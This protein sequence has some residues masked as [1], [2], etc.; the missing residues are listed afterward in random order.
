MCCNG[1]LA[2]LVAITAPS[3][4]VNSMGAVLI[5]AIA[6]VLV[7]VAV[8]AVERARVDDPV[9]AVAV[10]GVCGAWGVLSV[11]LFA[12]G[13]WGGGVNGVTHP[14][15]GLL[16]GGGAGQLIAQFCEMGACAVWA[17]GASFVF[18]KIQHAVQGIRSKSEDELAGLDVPELGIDA[19]PED[20]VAHG[21]HGA[22]TPSAVPAG[23]LAGVEP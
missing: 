18:F 16:F 9:G 23:Q 15:T 21:R 14:V 11:G 10:H 17:F 6:G 3:A 8:P 7:C 19:Y 12:D 1:L 4:Y 2:G 20:A 13:S 5:G 22:G